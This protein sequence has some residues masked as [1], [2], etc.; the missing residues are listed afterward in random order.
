MA[1]KLEGL[2]A[3]IVR[4]HCGDEFRPLESNSQGGV[5]H[6]VNAGLNPQWHAKCPSC[7]KY[8]K[9]PVVTS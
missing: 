9:G 1:H 6:P 8:S 4:Q 2:P 7:G 3:S 5:D